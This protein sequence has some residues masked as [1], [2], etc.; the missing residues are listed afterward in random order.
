MNNDRGFL[1]FDFCFS[2]V[3]AFVECAVITALMYAGFNGF[4]GVAMEYTK[5]GEAAVTAML[6]S[7]ISR[8][9]KV[10]DFTADRHYKRF[11][12]GRLSYQLNLILKKA[13]IMSIRSCRR[14][15][16]KLLGNY[17]TCRLAKICS[18]YICIF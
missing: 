16:T 3:L 6:T 2:L 8:P 11:W 13:E 15:K 5:N 14:F 17:I 1:K 9:K 7:T 4:G 10:D 12:L 18:T